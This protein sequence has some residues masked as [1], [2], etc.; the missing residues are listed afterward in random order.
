MTWRDKR[1]S[2]VE[3]RYLNRLNALFTA[4]I[5]TTG[6]IQ[7]DITG[8]VGQY[9]HG[10]EDCHPSRTSPR[11]PVIP[12]PRRSGSPPFAATCMPMPRMDFAAMK[13]VDK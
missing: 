4:P 1:T 9:A 5:Q 6:R 13:I 2:S 3:T 8:L 11:M 10:N 7:P 12:G